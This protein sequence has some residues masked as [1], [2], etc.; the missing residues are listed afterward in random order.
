MQPEDFF[1]QQKDSSNKTLK[2]IFRNR[3]K[4]NFLI[5]IKE[6]IQNRIWN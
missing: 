1:E 5:E 4:Q 6:R 3:I 2:N